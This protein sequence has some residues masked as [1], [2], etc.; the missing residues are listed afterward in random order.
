L[1]GD[2]FPVKRIK[3]S[4]KLNNSKGHGHTADHGTES[5]LTLI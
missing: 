1:W 4:W 3:Y 5:R 2:P